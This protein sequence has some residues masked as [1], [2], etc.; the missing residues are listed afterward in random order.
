M[1]KRTFILA[2]D[3][4]GTRHPD[5]KIGNLPAHG[6]DWF[7]LGGILF[8]ETDEHQIRDKHAAFCDHWGIDAPLHSVEIRAKAGAFSFLAE[9]GGEDLGRFHFELNEM[10]TGLPVWGHACVIDRPGY[11]ARYFPKYGRQRWLLCKSAFSIVV[12]RSAKFVR[13]RGGRLRVYIEK[14]DRKTDLTLKGYYDEM[15]GKGMPFS[16]ATSQKYK[17]AD[18]QALAETLFEFRPKAKSSPLAQLADLYLW[19]ICL[20]GYNHACRPFTS[21]K[22]AG[23]LIDCTIAEDEGECAIK[24]YC[25]DNKKAQ[26]QLGS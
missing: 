15:R 22:D 25:F 16:E 26:L 14:S 10:L 4:L 9:L 23:K 24:Y 17:P 5:R 13:N 3:D 2:L 20:A 1:S 18:A 12:E 21:L 11:D 19:P 6:N 7:S 8:D